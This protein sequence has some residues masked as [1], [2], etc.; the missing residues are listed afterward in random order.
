MTHEIPAIILQKAAKIKLVIFDVD[1]V[2]TDGHI[3]LDDQS[4][5]H[6]AFHVHDGLGLKLLMK[7]GVHVAI[8]SSGDA[9]SVARRMEM[10]GIT[11]VY[12][13]QN[14]KRKAFQELLDKEKLSA[15]QVCF[16]GDDLI[17]IP[18]VRA[19]GLGIA[20]ASA[21]PLVKQYADWIT[22]ASGGFGAAREI[23][24]LIMQ[25]QGK[26]ENVFEE[27]LK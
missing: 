23:C 10:L 21:V 26:L 18:L 7:T 11:A 16:A 14:D 17:D 19:A 6:K 13:R 27:Y 8:I 9:P 25:A 5:G 22:N 4:I 1:G 2:L 20:V 12:Q 15:E 24:E 3:Y